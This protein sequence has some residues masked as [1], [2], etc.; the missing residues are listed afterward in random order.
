MVKLLLSILL[1][2]TTVGDVYRPITSADFSAIHAVPWQPCKTVPETN[3]CWTTHANYSVPAV[4]P[5][6]PPLKSEHR[7]PT[8]AGTITTIQALILSVILPAW[9]V[10]HPAIPGVYPA[11]TLAHLQYAGVEGGRWVARL[12]VPS[13]VAGVP[14]LEDTISGTPPAYAVAAVSSLVNDYVI[15][16]VR[17]EKGLR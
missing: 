9:D 5:A 11:G 4:N 10:A 13:S 8:N 6:L 3:D 14:S 12:S 1:A 17:L 16:A 7:S 15:P 2:A